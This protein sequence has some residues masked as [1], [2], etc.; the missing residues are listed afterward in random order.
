M[1]A[2]IRD[3]APSVRVVVVKLTGRS[4]SVPLL[5]NGARSRLRSPLASPAT[6][7]LPPQATSANRARLASIVLVIPPSLSLAT[8]ATASVRDVLS[9]AQ[10][11]GLDQCRPPDPAAAEQALHVA[12][13]TLTVNRAVRLRVVLSFGAGEVDAGEQGFGLLVG[14]DLGA[15]LV[16]GLR[17]EIAPYRSGGHGS[18]AA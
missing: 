12:R 18:L 11:E 16:V 2:S 1:V 17:G 6:S 10:Q 7:G 13:P 8:P 15:E 3:P 14:V 4:L 5:A 9:Q